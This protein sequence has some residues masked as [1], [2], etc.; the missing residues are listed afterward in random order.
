MWVKFNGTSA[1]YSGTVLNGDGAS[2]TS[3]N[4]ISS[5]LGIAA[6]NINSGGSTTN[7]FTSYELYVPNYLVSQNKPTSGITAFEQ[8][9]TTAYLTAVAGLWSN[10]AAI[11]SIAFSLTSGDFASGSSFY[12][13]GI[14]NS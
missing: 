11:T 4:W 13:Y 12:L 6:E 9:S 5:T 3:W 7:S 14:K 10:T 1:N 8:N 2:A